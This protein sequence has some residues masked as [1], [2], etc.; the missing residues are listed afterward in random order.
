MKEKGS[1]TVR[2]GRALGAQHAIAGHLRTLHFHNISKLGSVAHL[3][4]E[5]QD[6]VLGRKVVILAVFCNF[7]PILFLAT[8]PGMVG[9]DANRPLRGC[10]VQEALR[11]LVY[12]EMVY[13]QFSRA[14]N[15]REK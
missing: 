12:L 9:N 4:F 13:T 10:L 7:P 8:L 11:C 5:K 15:S 14:R 3:Y 1:D 2:H 6:G